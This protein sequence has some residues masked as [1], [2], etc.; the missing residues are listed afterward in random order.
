MNKTIILK[1]KGFWDEEY[2]IVGVFSTKKK[3]Q[4]Y[5]KW[6]KENYPVLYES[7][8]WSEETF[9]IDKFYN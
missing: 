3:I 2:E 1:R 8:V 5:K 4:E 9:E 7:A 6:L